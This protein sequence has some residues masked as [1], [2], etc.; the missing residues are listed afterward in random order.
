[1]QGYV[2]R[3]NDIV[4][5]LLV[6]QQ[7]LTLPL[8]FDVQIGH[9]SYFTQGYFFSYAHSDVFSVDCRVILTLTM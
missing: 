1:M 6:S 9:C 3:L 8:S 4:L 7:T 5:G 2:L